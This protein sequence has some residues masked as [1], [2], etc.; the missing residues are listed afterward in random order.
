MR[1]AETWPGVAVVVPTLAT[2]ATDR[3]FVNSA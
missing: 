2:G 3:R 1:A